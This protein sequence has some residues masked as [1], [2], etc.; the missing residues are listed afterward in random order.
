M[1]RGL[2]ANTNRSEQ[3]WAT[4]PATHVLFL[5]DEKKEVTHLLRTRQKVILGLNEPKEDCSEVQKMAEGA[6]CPI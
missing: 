5:P 6:M 3:F 1:L 2:F 4:A